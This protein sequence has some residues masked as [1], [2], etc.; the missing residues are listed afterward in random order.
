MTIKQFCFYFILISLFSCKKENMPV[1][2]ETTNHTCNDENVDLGTFY[3]DNRGDDALKYFPYSFEKKK[4]YFVDSNS[5]NL[6]L[7]LTNFDTTFNYDFASV[8]CAQDNRVLES[9][10][11]EEESI[12]VNLVDSLSL[13]RYTVSI[14]AD[15][16]SENPTQKIDTDKILIKLFEF[17][18]SGFVNFFKLRLNEIED[19][20]QR[21]IFHSE[22][23]LN[24]RDY[25]NVF[26]T[27]GTYKGVKIKYYY[28]FKIGLVAFNLFP[29][30]EL[31]SFDRIE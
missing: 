15:L 30:G 3:I 24:G 9:Y 11:W 7:H 13:N 22:I 19:L 10:T 12:T 4:Y 16:D 2:V 17:G 8:R 20:P 25:N 14:S 23:N 31:Y 1:N 26:Q 29:S 5:N 6:I 18:S 27:F 28:N 21:I